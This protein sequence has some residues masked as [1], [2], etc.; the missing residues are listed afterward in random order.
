MGRGEVQDK[1]ADLVVLGVGQCI[2]VTLSAAT[3]VST[4]R[5]A[6]QPEVALNVP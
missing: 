5:R 3:V 6:I 1:P 2:L 4:F